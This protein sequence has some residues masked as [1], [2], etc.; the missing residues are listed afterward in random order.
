MKV[1]TA[2]GREKY[3]LVNKFEKTN[4]GFMQ[5]RKWSFGFHKM[6][7]ASWLAENLIPSQ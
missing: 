1:S 2:A 5:E 4:G 3:R 7:K 6:R